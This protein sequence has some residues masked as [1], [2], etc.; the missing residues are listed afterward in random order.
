M[1]FLS[2]AKSFSST[3]MLCLWPDYKSI[4]QW[5]FFHIKKNKERK[6]LN[7]PSVTCGIHG[8]IQTFDGAF[9]PT[10]RRALL[11]K[12]FLSE[13]SRDLTERL[14]S[15]S[16]AS[17]LCEKRFLEHVCNWSTSAALTCV[18]C[19][20]A[21]MPASSRGSADRTAL[22]SLYTLVI[23]WFIRSCTCVSLRVCD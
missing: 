16:A 6:S 20:D 22:T 7:E 1:I 10:Q 13:R 23:G 2:Q 4:G 15:A 3:W 14:V 19:L 9:V 11:F 8:K 12:D 17:R 18:H 5:P 21:Q